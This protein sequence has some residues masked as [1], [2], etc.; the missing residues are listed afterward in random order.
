M[1]QEKTKINTRDIENKLRS[2]KLPD[3]T[4]KCIRINRVDET[5]FQ[6]DARNDFKVQ[7]NKSSRKT[8][9]AHHSIE[10][11]ELQGIS[12]SYLNKCSW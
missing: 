9:R 6:K 4:L 10:H 2:I 11:M 8:T 1:D 12:R 5:K 7:K 3:G